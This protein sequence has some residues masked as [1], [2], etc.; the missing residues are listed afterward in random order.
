MS[1]GNNNQ[2]YASATTR[3]GLGWIA[4][5]V[6]AWAG[7][8]VLLISPND[9][10]DEKSAPEMLDKH[11]GGFPDFPSKM[12]ADEFEVLREWAAQGKASAFS[13][14][15]DEKSDKTDY[16]I[17]ITPK[18]DQ[19]KDGLASSLSGIP[20]DKLRVPGTD[21]EWRAF[22][23]MHEAGHSD[24]KINKDLSLAGSLGREIEADNDAVRIYHD[25]LKRGNVKTAEVPEAFMAMRAISGFT[26]KS[27][28]P[29]HLT[30]LG[31]HLPGE[32]HSHASD[33]PQIYAKSLVS[34]R[35]KVWHE[36]GKDLMGPSAEKA[37]FKKFFEGDDFEKLNKEDRMT[38][39]DL[40]EGKLTMQE[41]QKKMSSEGF[42]KIK[43][44]WDD[45]ASAEGVTAAGDDPQLMYETTRKLYL[46]GTFDDS[47][48]EKKAAWQFLDAGRKYA[49]E[50]FGVEDPAASLPAPGQ[51]KRTAM[52]VSP[53][54]A[55]VPAFT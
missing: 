37:A 31:V 7:R 44:V 24:Q 30:R 21:Q 43:D 14:S 15:V 35:R 52:P 53:A 47:P 54:P 2:V 19:T 4:D 40:S 12:F 29:T 13:R 9:I 38:A 34:A 26:A 17:L 55:A 51:E 11:M 22:I 42:K 32:E 3:N 28:M 48:L 8:P 25:E 33:T 10:P 50:H 23:M 27:D 39:F 41:A 45:K 6:G 1:A 18:L 36:I 20:E 49:P 5:R 46:K 16:S